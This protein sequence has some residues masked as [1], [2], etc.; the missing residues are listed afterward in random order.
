MKKKY[1]N[2]SIFSL[3]RY[4]RLASLTDHIVV[5]VIDIVLSIAYT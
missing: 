3:I 1:I 2:H 4:E 5:N